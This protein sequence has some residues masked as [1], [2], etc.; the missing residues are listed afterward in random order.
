[1]SHQVLPG[2]SQ[3]KSDKEMAYSFSHGWKTP[4]FL[5]N[6]DT[7]TEFFDSTPNFSFGYQ[8]VSHF[9][10]A[11]QGLWALNTPVRSSNFSRNE[12]SHVP[13]RAVL[14]ANRIFFDEIKFF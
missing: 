7:E 11:F 9:L 6:T 5:V 3:D 14:L 1:M 12:L 2:I 10:I 4:T 13:Y 8:S